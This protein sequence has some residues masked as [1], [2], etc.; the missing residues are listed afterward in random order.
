MGRRQSPPKRH[1]GP[2]TSSLPRDAT[3]ATNFSPAFDCFERFFCESTRVRGLNERHFARV[4]SGDG[5]LSALAGVK[6]PTRLAGLSEFRR[7]NFLR[8]GWVW[9]QDSFPPPQSL[10]D[11]YRSNLTGKN[12]S[13][14]GRISGYTFDRRA[15]DLLI[16]R[17]LFGDEFQN[18]F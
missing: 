1:N 3:A 7:P 6:L 9:A 13:L 4:G 12:L 15:R 5:S 10:F 2:I 11:R 17:V 14:R 16:Q 18:Q 8:N